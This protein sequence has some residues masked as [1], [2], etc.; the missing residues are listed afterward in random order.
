MREASSERNPTFGAW[1][2]ADPPTHGLGTGHALLPTSPG[3]DWHCLPASGTPQMLNPAQHQAW[4]PDLLVGRCVL[5][6]QEKWI[7]GPCHHHAE[8]MLWKEV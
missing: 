1:P 4:V 7:P 6:N 5:F 3:A 8:L 2:G